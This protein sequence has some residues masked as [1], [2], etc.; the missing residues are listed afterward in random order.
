MVKTELK[1]TFDPAYWTGSFKSVKSKLQ[2]IR[3]EKMNKWLSPRRFGIPQNQTDK[4]AQNF[5]HFFQRFKHCF[6]A[7]KWNNFKYGKIYIKGVL[8]LDTG[9]NFTNITRRIMG[10]EHSCDN[11]QNFM[12]DS[13]WSSWQVFREIQNQINRDP[14]FCNGIL[15]VDESGD[16]K[17]GDKTAGT[18]NQ[19]SG[20]LRKKEIV[21]TG[22]VLG[23]YKDGNWA[24]VDSELYIKKEWFEEA[25]ADKLKKTCIPK[26]KKFMTKAQIALEMI[27]RAKQNGLQFSAVTGDAIYGR[28]GSLRRALDE[29]GITY[30]LDNSTDFTVYLEKP[31]FA[32]P[33]SPRP[34]SRPGTVNRIKAVSVK[35]L[36]N[37]PG[38]F[39]KKLQIRNIE[40]GILEN[41]F[42]ACRV[43]T[44]PSEGPSRE[45]WLLIRRQKNGKVSFSLSNAPETATIQELATLRCSRYF[46]ERIFEDCK[47]ELGWD[48]FEAQK[49]LAWMHHTALTGLALWFITY[50]KLDWNRL[51]PKDPILAEEMRV[52]VLPQL[53]VSNVREFFRKAFP[54]SELSSTDIEMLVARKLRNRA[55]STASRLKK[56]KMLISQTNE[57]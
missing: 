22:V 45:E 29:Q 51:Y 10:V 27:L 9:R 30:M 13:P 31:E 23:Y 7:G 15:T 55:R 37:H 17:S 41:E 34:Y 11:I 49:Y 19:Y 56:K 47:S 18:G 44:L 3:P 48:E 50:C 53:S 57:G 8:S 54:I 42:Y 32:A 40:R 46:A 33:R 6:K 26:D 43:W 38:V 1:K 21:Q 14:D 25:N 35:S 28:D 52:I 16:Q 2:N 20:R 39:L 36:L 24:M 12:S 5:E 4:L